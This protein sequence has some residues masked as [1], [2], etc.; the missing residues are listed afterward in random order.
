[1][2]P[3]FVPHIIDCGGCIMF[4]SFQVREQ[5]E[6]L[7]A[8]TVAEVEQLVSLTP[9]LSAM[10]DEMKALVAPKHQEAISK[11]APLLPGEPFAKDL[12]EEI[13]PEPLS[14][15]GSRQSTPRGSRSRPMTPTE[16]PQA[17]NS[18][19]PPSPTNP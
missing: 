9:E 8:E 17:T 3:S 10:R 19:E 1:M 13:T 7:V 12:T 16:P 5:V 14:P 6:R 2:Q 18:E 4:C 15:F 11:N